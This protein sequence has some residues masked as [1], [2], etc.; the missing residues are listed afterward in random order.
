MTSTLSTPTRHPLVGFVDRLH[1]VLDSLSD[2]PAWSLTRPEQQ[3]VLLDLARERARLDELWLRVLAAA[4]R[5]DVAA[6]T[7]ATSTTA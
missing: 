4:D 3:R 6:E 1:T 5:D 2:V 7:G